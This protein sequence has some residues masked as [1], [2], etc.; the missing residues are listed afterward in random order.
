MLVQ[1]DLLDLQDLRDRM[2]SKVQPVH[3]DFKEILVHPDKQDLL[4][5]QARRVQ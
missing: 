3:P 4:G 5:I 1:L 2:V